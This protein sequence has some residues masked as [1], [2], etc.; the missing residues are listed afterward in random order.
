ML[1]H[2]S[3]LQPIYYFPPEDVRTDVLEPSDRHTRCPK[4]GDASYYTIRVGDRVVEN[5]AWYYPEPLD[6]AP[7]IKDLIAFY[8]DRMDRW[9]EEDEEVGV[10]PRD[11]YHRID[12]LTTDRHVRSR[13]RESCWPTAAARGAVR[14]Q[15]AAPLVPPA[16]GRDR[17]ARAD[18]TPSL[19]ARTRARPATTRCRRRRRLIWYYD[20]PLP[21]VA[22][23]RACSASST[24]R[25]TSSST[26]S[27]R[28]APRRRGAAG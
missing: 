2:E 1:L 26:A 16:R 6:G 21:E 28:S 5:G 4:K 15:P 20:D 22:G 9:L 11:P 10:H 13:W 7:P 23:S 18:A 8:L 24:R 19:S 25:S 12:I 14:V 17:R 27:C 3:G